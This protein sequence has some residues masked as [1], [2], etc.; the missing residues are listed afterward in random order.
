MG[1][2]S[3]FI[4]IPTGDLAEILLLAS[5]FL[6]LCP[7]IGSCDRGT[8]GISTS[9]FPLLFFL[10]PIS[11]LFFS[12]L[13]GGGLGSLLGSLGAIRRLRR[14]SRG[15]WLSFF[16]LLVIWLLGRQLSIQR[17]VALGKSL[18]E[19]PTGESLE[20]GLDFGPG[21]HLDQIVLAKL[22][23]TFFVNLQS[24]RKSEALI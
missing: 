23:S 14:Q 16:R 11:F 8:T 20:L 24:Y 2:V 6:L 7:R 19:I 17:S 1:I 9:F 18:I 22:H 10:L 12:G 3:F 21:R 5:L 4:A 13:L 15:F